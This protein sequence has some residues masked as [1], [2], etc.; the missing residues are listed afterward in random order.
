MDELTAFFPKSSV[1]V[2]TQMEDI[3]LSPIE[4]DDDVLCFDLTQLRQSFDVLIVIATSDAEGR[5]TDNFGPFFLAL[6]KAAASDDIPLTGLQHAVIGK[7]VAGAQ[8]AFQ[9]IPRLIDKYL[10]ECGSR[11]AIMRHE[12]T[13]QASDVTRH[14]FLEA[15]RETLQA[16]PSHAAASVCEWTRALRSDAEPTDGVIV[17]S[18]EELAAF[19]PREPDVAW[20]SREL[21]VIGSVTAACALLFA[22]Y[23]QQLSD[24]FHQGAYYSGYYIAMSVTLGGLREVLLRIR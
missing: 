16:P 4:D 24:N 20:T 13:A 14:A 7:G 5:A 11:R 17:R 8:G 6:L 19:A 15:V 10:G 12:I 3:G 21:L 2:A 22:W 18:A 23:Y 9:N 1:T